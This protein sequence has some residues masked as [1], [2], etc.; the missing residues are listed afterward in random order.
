[1]RFHFP[2]FLIGYAAGTTT[3]LLGREL[4]PIAIEGAT[5][6]YQLW[7]ALWARAATLGEDIED[8]LVEARARAGSS[9]DSTS[10]TASAS[11]ATKPT[12]GPTSS[13]VSLTARRTTRARPH[14]PSTSGA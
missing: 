8:I 3:V 6:M 2:S 5:A 11:A 7:D 10:S 14:R 9:G 1:M 12:Q 4:K 13:S